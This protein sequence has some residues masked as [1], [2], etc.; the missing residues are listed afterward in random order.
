MAINMYKLSD[1]ILL[2]ITGKEGFEGIERNSETSSYHSWESSETTS[3]EYSQ[4][5]AVYC[6]YSIKDMCK[7]TPNG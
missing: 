4:E 7:E 5:L 1:S 6:K 3:Y 2:L